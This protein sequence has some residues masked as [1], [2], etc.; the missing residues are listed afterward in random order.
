MMNLVSTTVQRMLQ[1][2]GFWRPE[3]GRLFIPDL[4]SRPEW[5]VELEQ[6]WGADNGCYSGFDRRK[7]VRM[8]RV[9]EG[10]PGA[11]FV[12]APDV[13]GKAEPTLELFD[14]WGPRIRSHGL[15]VAL[16][17]QDGLEDLEIPWDR[18]DA[19]FVGGTDK[20]KLSEPCNS[21]IAQAQSKGL[22]VH[23]G[24]IN[25]IEATQICME[26]GV[27]SVDGSKY[28]KYTATWIPRYLDLLEQ[29][30]P[31]RLEVAV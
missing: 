9:L 3:I 23:V 2:P 13:V 22:H 7:F 24:R 19:M 8:L 10:K 29:P 15:P 6:F 27:D 18:M 16:V 31:N 25:S 30:L 12:C 26:L 14:K 5:T 11:L 21:L 17:A 20:W 28:G 1:A 4:Y